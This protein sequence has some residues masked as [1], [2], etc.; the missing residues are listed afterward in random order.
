MTDTARARRTDP[1]TSH[2]A[3]ASID[4]ERIRLSQHAVL[5]HF[6]RH[7]PMTDTELIEGYDGKI[8][9]TDSG[10]RT[11]RS[12]LVKKGLLVDTGRRELLETGRSSKVWGLPPKK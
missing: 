4:G 10:L 5:R 8:P 6:R 9:Q 7:G 12:E 2:Q 3:A 11:R 1:I